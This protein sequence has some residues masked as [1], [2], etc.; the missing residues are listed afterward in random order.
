MAAG[1]VAIFISGLLL[2]AADVDTYW[3]SRVYWLKMALVALLL[4]NGAFLMIA[5]RQLQLGHPKA[6][7]RLRNAAHASLSLWF[8]TTLDGAALPNIG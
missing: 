6:W 8:R 1:L 5:E 4:A 3:H 7:A 2:L